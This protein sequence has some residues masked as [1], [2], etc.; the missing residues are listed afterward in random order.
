MMTSRLLTPGPFPGVPG[1]GE[2]EGYFLTNSAAD[3]R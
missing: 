3:G 1:R 2:T